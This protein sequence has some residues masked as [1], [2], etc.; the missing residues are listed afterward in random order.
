MKKLI[1][2][3]EEKTRQYGDFLSQLI[4]LDDDKDGNV[5]GIKDGAA[6]AQVWN[7]KD[8]ISNA[9]HI[10]SEQYILFIGNS[11][12]QKEKRAHMV[13]KYS[14]YGIKYGWLG[15]QTALSGR[16]NLEMDEYTK[17]IEFAQGYLSNVKQLVVKQNDLFVIEP[18]KTVSDE[19]NGGIKKYI[20]T[21][22]N[23]P[24]AIVNAP[25]KGVNA[26]NMLANSKK[27]EEQQYTCAVMLF[28]L[29]GINEF[30]GL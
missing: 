2:V 15:K 3:C 18:E 10:S 9:A 24:V 26:L 20:N 17:F 14:D 25:G 4:S 16:K 13:V 27:I 19:K 8:Y 23:I 30:L 29:N 7:E 5:R 6:A 28:Y 12:L 22:K 21:L 11:K 1:I